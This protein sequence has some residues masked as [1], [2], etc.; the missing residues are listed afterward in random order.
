MLRVENLY[1]Y[2][3]RVAGIQGVSLEVA[4]GEIVGLLGANGA[5]KS[6]T[7]GAIAG[8]YRPRSGRVLFEG[9]DLQ[10]VQPENVVRKGIALVP[11]NRRIFGHLTVQENLRLGATIRN[12]AAGVERDIERIFRHFPVLKRL[13]KSS[14]GGLSGGEQQQLAIGR[15]LLSNPKL[16]LLDE[17]SLGLAPL[18]VKRVFDVIAE[19]RNEG[20]TIL[21]A[22]QY[23]ART[24]ELADR[25]YSLSRGQVALAGNAAELRKS[26]D[27]ETNYLLGLAPARR[28]AS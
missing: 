24:L 11:E 19:L 25:V 10:R 28:E 17:P 8:L 16:L 6:T 22:E 14:A 23:V 13:Y 7:L 1:V 21:L 20:V 15:A 12:D 3:G 5:G 26:T 2:H 27:F 18:L 9:G 4:P